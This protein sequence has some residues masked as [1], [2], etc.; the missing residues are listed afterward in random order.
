MFTGIIE[1]LGT[2]RAV[3]PM[4]SGRRLTVE[5][6]FPLPDSRVGD[7]LAVNGTCLTAVAL[8]G[9]RFEADV[10][11]ETLARI[12]ELQDEVHQ[13]TLA[14]ERMALR[15]EA[16]HAERERLHRENENLAQEMRRLEVGIRE[17]ESRRGDP[18]ER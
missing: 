18:V 3:R 11:P 10:S 1:G 13:R 8:D 9:R 2:I 16:A 7:S 12:A 14:M 15:A 5:A 4:G 6:G 17:L